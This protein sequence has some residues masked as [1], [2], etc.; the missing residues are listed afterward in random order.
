MAVLAAS[1]QL[2]QVDAGR[3][4]CYLPMIY[5]K[6]RRATPTF[7]AGREAS[8]QVDS[9]PLA[10]VAIFI[11]RSEKPVMIN[12]RMIPIIAELNDEGNS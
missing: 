3:S 5:R 9:V 7:T 1:R 4:R 10:T 11:A 12:A 6:F 8:D 2:P